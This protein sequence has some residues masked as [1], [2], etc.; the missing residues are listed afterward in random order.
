MRTDRWPLNAVLLEKGGRF[1]VYDIGLG[2]IASDESVAGAYEKFAN[3]R[4]GFIEEVERAGLTVARSSTPAQSVLPATR[5]G[6]AA[7]L[8]PFLVKTC[9]VVLLVVAIGAFGVSFAVGVVTRSIGNLAATASQIAGPLKSISMSDIATKA[10]DIVRDVQAMPQER[11]ESLRQSIGILSREAEPIVE[12]WR[13][14]PRPA[15]V[16]PDST[17]SPATN[18]SGR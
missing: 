9:M 8:G 3:T 10:E 16:R 12:A 14:P 2:V 7:E 5:Q 17:S 6:I 15:S 1:F 4:R 18:N 13:N 11:K